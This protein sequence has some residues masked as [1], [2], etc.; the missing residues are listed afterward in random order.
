MN[1][2]K[3]ISKRVRGQM[4]HGA[5]QGGGINTA[6]TPGDRTP[7]LPYRTVG[8]RY[9]FPRI[10]KISGRWRVDS[11]RSCMWHEIRCFLPMQRIVGRRSQSLSCTF[12]RCLIRRFGQWGLS[13]LGDHRFRHWQ[14]KHGKMHNRHHMPHRG[15]FLSGGIA[16]LSLLNKNGFIL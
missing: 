11:H 12:G 4:V 13:R 15:S 16:Y 8:Y 3:E 10:A 2:I 14:P 7:P 6:K 9:C 5:A 1:W